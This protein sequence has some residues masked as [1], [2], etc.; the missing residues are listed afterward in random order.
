MIKTIVVATDGSGHAAKALKLAADL[1]NKYRARLVLVHALLRDAPAGE[2]RRLANMRKLTKAQR[3]LLEAFESEP[4]M[5][6]ASA[7]VGGAF[8]PIPPPREVLEPVGRQILERAAAAAK[9]AGVKR[10]TATLASGDA[11]DAILAEAKKAK[12]DM[13]VMGS[14]GFGDL[15]GLLLG[16]VSHKVAAHADCSVVTVK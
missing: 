10:L 6:M 11:A 2:L 5:A 8:I 1:A 13:I 3:D 16:S 9:K 4:Q 7:G 14:R 12:A 15:R